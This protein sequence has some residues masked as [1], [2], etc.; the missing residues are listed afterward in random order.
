[1]TTILAV[2]GVLG[3]F[4]DDFLTPEQQAKWV[5]RLLFPRWYWL[6]IGF[7]VITVIAI[8]EGAYR[9]HA[10]KVKELNAS[11][12]TNV[13]G[14]KE[15]H[16]SAIEQLEKQHE[17]DLT[18]LNEGHRKM[19][20]ALMK[21]HE[22]EVEWRKEIF[23]STV[24]SNAKSMK[25]I[26]NR[27]RAQAEEQSRKIRVQS[28]RILKLTKQTEHKLIFEVHPKPQSQAYV[29]YHPSFNKYLITANLE[30]HLEN[31]DTTPRTIKRWEAWLIRKTKRGTEKKIREASILVLDKSGKETT[32]ERVD[33][34]GI[35]PDHWLHCALELPARYG[36]RLNQNCFLRVTL[37][38]TRQKPYPLDLD[39]DWQKAYTSGT[40]VYVTPR[41]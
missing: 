36:K 5:M 6:V 34:L 2:W 23:K 10:R 24:D 38:A 18:E 11:H 39:V 8:L 4:R 22:K 3:S 14:I 33:I 1:M 15:T 29:Q 12:D 17:S 16:K 37:E 28:S 20:L 41:K 40:N 27:Y 13:E 31:H 32:L 9:T 35:T 26:H 7:L 30:I 21:I 19:H 25:D